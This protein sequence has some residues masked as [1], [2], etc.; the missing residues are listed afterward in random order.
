MFYATVRLE[1]DTDERALLQEVARGDRAAFKLLYDRHADYVYTLALRLLGNP[2]DAEEVSQDVFTTL[3]KKA[4]DIRGDSKL[5][6][7][8][9]RVTINKSL[10]FRRSGGVMA[11]VRQVLSLDTA[12]ISPAD[13]LPAPESERPDRLYEQVEAALTLADLMAQ[14]PE[15]Q[16]EVYL[17]HKLSGL[18]YYEVAEELSMT[19]SSVESLMHRAKQNLQKAAVKKVESCA[20]WRRNRVSYGR[21]I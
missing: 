15:R 8:L 4:R 19:L 5:S 13:E 16:R 11:R 3:W 17:L 10:N 14:I 9:H 20:R 18:S 1:P 6:T 7:W 21:R 2:Q 12:D